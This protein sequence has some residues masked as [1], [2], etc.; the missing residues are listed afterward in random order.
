MMM[1]ETGKMLWAPPTCVQH[2]GETWGAGEVGDPPKGCSS[3]LSPAALLVYRVF[4]HEAKRSTKALHALLHGLALVVALVG[5]RRGR[6]GWM[7]GWG[8]I[9]P[10][11]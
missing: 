11:R 9:R 3:A 5:E 7:D 8:L 1:N 6:P 2:P 10:R 4:R